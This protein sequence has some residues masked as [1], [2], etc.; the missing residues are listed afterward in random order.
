[1]T[2][3]DL[4]ADANRLAHYLKS[5]GVASGRPRRDLREEQHRARRRRAG[6]GQDPGGHD[7]RELP[8]RR[9]R[10]R[11]PL[12]QLRRGRRD[13]RAHLRPAGRRLHAQA[14]QAP[15]RSR[16][17]RRAR[18]RRPVRRVVVR[19]RALGGR[20]RRPER[21]ARLRRAQPRR[22]PHHLHRRHHRLPE[23]RDVA[24]RG[25]LAGA[26]RRHRLLHRCAAR[27]VRPVQAGHRPPDGDV[28][29]E[30]ADARR[31][32]GGAPDAPLRRPSDGARAEVRPG[33]HLGDHRARG[34]AADLHD[35]RRDGPPADRGVRGATA[36]TSAPT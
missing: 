20:A 28:P 36:A 31:R 16:R 24:A 4:E 9:G 3:A 10:A 30:P 7:Q 27:G 15:G 19:R 22:P 8:V 29:A 13:P 25:L 12:R 2:Y 21:R 17:A 14:R 18:T 5:Q 33:P 34:R 23:G 11:L 26:R 1:M 35:R 32:P 6:R